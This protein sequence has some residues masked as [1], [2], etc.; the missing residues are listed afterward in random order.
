VT[1]RPRALAPLLLLASLASGCGAP[2]RDVKAP[3]TLPVRAA[4]E[5]AAEDA[6][7]A[8]C[9]EACAT[10]LSSGPACEQ[11]CLEAHPIVQVELIGPT[12]R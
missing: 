4:E 10:E 7:R 9:L 1:L 11:T 5:L 3:G 2:R 8:A 6:A 12:P